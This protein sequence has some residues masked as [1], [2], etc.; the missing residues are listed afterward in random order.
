[1]I[2]YAYNLQV[3]PPAP[4]VLVNLR[5]PMTG[6]AVRDVP[7][8]IDT[9]ADCTVLPESVSLALALIASG[10][11]TAT[12]FAGI[13]TQV[14]LYPVELGIHTEAPQPLEVLT[15]PEEAWVLL[16]RDVLNGKRVLLDGPG[17]ALEIG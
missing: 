11:A 14:S 3:Q 1:V 8:Q 17:L 12:G 2:R 13:P 6:A 9:G 10:Q 15:S 4:F 16:G 5:S 7:A